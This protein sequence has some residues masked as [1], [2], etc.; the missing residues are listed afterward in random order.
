MPYPDR[1]PL[2]LTAV[3]RCLEGSGSA[4]LGGREVGPE[5]A[6]LE[7]AEGTEHPENGSRGKLGG[8]SEYTV[9]RPALGDYSGAQDRGVLVGALVPVDGYQACLCDFGAPGLPLRTPHQL[10]RFYF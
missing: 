6:P 9:A 4:R 5:R 10:G 8:R 3:G 2:G 7:P 1:A